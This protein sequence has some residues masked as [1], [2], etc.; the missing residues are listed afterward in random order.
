M[1]VVEKLAQRLELTRGDAECL[2]RAS[3]PLLGKLVEVQGHRPPPVAAWLVQGLIA[4]G[5]IPAAGTPQDRPMTIGQPVVADTALF[6]D[7]LFALRETLSAAGRPAAWYPEPGGTLDQFSATGDEATG[8]EVLRAVALA[9]L[10]LPAQ[11]TIVAPLNVLGSKVAQVALEYGASRFGFLAAEAA[12]GSAKDCPDA[13]PAEPVAHAAAM[14]QLAELVRDN[15]ATP[16]GA[17]R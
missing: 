9:R 4:C 6:L 15:V 5:A 7:T 14:A 1:P 10:V 16:I 2:A 11:V 17:S 8:W 3:L 13:A 12:T